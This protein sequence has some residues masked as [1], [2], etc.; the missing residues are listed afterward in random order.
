M[1]IKYENTKVKQILL[2]YP[3]FSMS[4][5]QVKATSPSLFLYE[6]IHNTS[7]YNHKVFFAVFLFI[8]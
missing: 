2:H 6:T 5:L 7:L 1:N 4:L 3:D 8:Y